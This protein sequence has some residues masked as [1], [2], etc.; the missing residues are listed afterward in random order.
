MQIINLNLRKNPII[1][2]FY[3]IQFTELP[4]FQNHRL[5]GGESFHKPAIL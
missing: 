3:L 5:T 2:N 1:K 4:P